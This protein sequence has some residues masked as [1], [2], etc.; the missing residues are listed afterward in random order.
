VHDTA[1]A[2]GQKLFEIYVKEDPT[3][4]VEIGAMNVNGTL[5]DLCP[6]WATYLGLDVDHGPGVDLLIRPS[7][8]LPLRSDYADVVLSTSQM[9]HDPIF[10]RTFLELMRILKPGGVLY[11]N[12]PSNGTYHCFPADYWRFY[13]DAAMALE[14]WGRENG[15]ETTL[16]ESFVAERMSDIWNDFVA[17]FKKSNSV[18]CDDVVLLSDHFGCTNVRSI[19]FEGIARPRETPE[20]AVVIAK[21]AM[22]AATARAEAKELAAEIA[23]LRAQLAGQLIGKEPSMPDIDIIG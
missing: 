22:E 9:E 8:N 21:F 20:D 6:P 23:N 3:I 15:Y 13:P 12:V 16:I 4:I 17:V 2:I 1:Y 18:S 19:K 14:L 7:E 10:W 5:R 11:L